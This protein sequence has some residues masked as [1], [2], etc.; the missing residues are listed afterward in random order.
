MLGK[1]Q[2]KKNRNKYSCTKLTR[3][4]INNRGKKKVTFKNP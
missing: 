1:K 3:N 4:D 2:R